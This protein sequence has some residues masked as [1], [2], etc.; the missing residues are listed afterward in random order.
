MSAAPAADVNAT[1]AT[2]PANE[3]LNLIVIPFFTFKPLKSD[4]IE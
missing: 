4:V 3:Y 1:D 2:T